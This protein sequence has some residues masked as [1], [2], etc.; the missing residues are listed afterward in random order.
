MKKATVNL[1]RLCLETLE[2]R[3]LPGNLLSAIQVGN[4]FAPKNELRLDKP[5]ED[6]PG[7]LMVSGLDFS[8]Y[9]NFPRVETARV[10]GYQS[11]LQTS[12]PDDNAP[13]LLAD[14]RTD[15]QSLTDLGSFKK[16]SPSRG[17]SPFN[18]QQ[19]DDLTILSTFVSLNQAATQARSSDAGTGAQTPIV[20][21]TN[22]GA[23]DELLGYVS[24]KQQ[25]PDD[26]PI[27]M[28]TSE[29]PVVHQDVPINANDDNGSAIVEYIPNK[30]DFQASKAD[31][32]ANTPDTDLVAMTM[33]DDT[34]PPSPVFTRGVYSYTLSVS[35]PPVAGHLKLWDSQ[36][37]DHEYTVF[38]VE[39]TANLTPNLIEGF[40]DWPKIYLEGTEP[41]LV[42][43]DI[44]INLSVKWDVNGAVWTSTY[45]TV[46]LTVTPRIQ[47]FIIHNT[48][49]F[50]GQIPNPNGNNPPKIGGPNSKTNYYGY[51]EFKVVLAGLLIGTPQFVQ[52]VVEGTQD[53]LNNGSHFLEL[54]HPV[55]PRYKHIFSPAGTSF[56]LIDSVTANQIPYYKYH[57]DR[58]DNFMD[59]GPDPF[60][61][62]LYNL[63]ASDMPGTEGSGNLAG[64]LWM[65]LKYTMNFKLWVVLSITN[66]NGQNNMYP[67]ART[68]WVAN[69]E[70]DT[71]VA[72][73][74][75]TNKKGSIVPDPAG[76]VITHAK[77]DTTIPPNAKTTWVPTPAN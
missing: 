54:D 72:G 67:L 37:K 28:M 57:S 75:L 52:N 39:T 35:Q 24:Q 9:V 2:D 32:P 41:S 34:P 5:L 16:E 4:Y 74:G 14:I 17:D 33:I 10:T 40:Y 59:V 29:A 47:T 20:V 12:K 63:N 70:A 53:Q 73:S 45:R 69:L 11:E 49:N 6:Q 46:K 76:Y 68:A 18:W 62:R 43:D 65:N 55:T 60:N 38:G 7:S 21:T 22:Q 36:T 51:A 23:D 58:Y 50:F 30:Y 15:G 8:S 61:N 3:Q 66:R 42:D 13:D 27:R 31:Y 44:T 25:Q 77:P 56:P 71:Y 48:D 64:D 1:V 26:P 19:Q